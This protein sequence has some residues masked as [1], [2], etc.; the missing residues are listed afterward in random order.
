MLNLS[1]PCCKPCDDIKKI[2]DSE[3]NRTIS[4]HLDFKEADIIWS[5]KHNSLLEV[6]DYIR[7]KFKKIDLNLER[8]KSLKF[9]QN[10]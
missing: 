10:V 7:Q 5:D 8:F 9:K 3:A 2:L 6:E 4:A 1:K